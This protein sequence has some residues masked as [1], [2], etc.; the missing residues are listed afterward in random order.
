MPIS[1]ILTLTALTTSLEKFGMMARSSSG[2]F[3]LAIPS[4]GT[5]GSSWSL[6]HFSAVAVLDLRQDFRIRLLHL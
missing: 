3:R 6:I 5:N 1:H 2:D 4:N